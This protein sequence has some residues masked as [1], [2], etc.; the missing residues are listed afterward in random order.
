M[1]APYVNMPEVVRSIGDRVLRCG[2][3]NCHSGGSGPS[4][5]SSRFFATRPAL[6]VRLRARAGY[7]SSSWRAVNAPAVSPVYN[8]TFITRYFLIRCGRCDANRPAGRYTPHAFGAHSR[9]G[10]IALRVLFPFKEYAADPA[11]VI[12]PD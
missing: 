9:I 1:S 10:A 12:R 4:R 3:N 11:S 2:L 8:I 6:I 5:I 7:N